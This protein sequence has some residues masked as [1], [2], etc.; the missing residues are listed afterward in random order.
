MELKRLNYLY[1]HNNSLCTNG[2]LDGEKDIK[3]L[4]ERKPG[5][6]CVKQCSIYCQNRLKSNNYCAVDCNTKDC[7]F[8]GGDCLQ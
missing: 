2:W 1:I 4:V 6:G 7:K 3:A 5:A 8:D